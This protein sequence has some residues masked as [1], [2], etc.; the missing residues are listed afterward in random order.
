M[1]KGVPTSFDKPFANQ[2]DDELREEGREQSDETVEELQRRK[3]EALERQV[4]NMMGMLGDVAKKTG[5]APKRQPGEIMDG[6]AFI[7]LNHLKNAIIEN[8][9]KLG[10][11]VAYDEMTGKQID[12]QTM[13][14]TTADGETH[15]MPYPHYQQM[16]GTNK[17]PVRIVGSHQRDNNGF[18]RWRLTT[19]PENEL[20][21][22]VGRT[23][24]GRHVF[25][26]TSPKM[27][28]KFAILNA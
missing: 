20:E 19:E 8:H 14:F 1:S 6:E 27:K 26:E 2:A 16:T 10:S 5:L 24:K 25:D 12:R 13:V 23:V 17:T 7:P 11:F 21:I 28:V 15:E 9:M 4:N 22:I 18:F 3:I